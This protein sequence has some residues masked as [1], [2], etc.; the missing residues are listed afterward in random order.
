LDT[1]FSKRF[2]HY[3]VLCG[4]WQHNW[5]GAVGGKKQQ[6][7]LCRQAHHGKQQANPN[8]VEGLVSWS[9]PEFFIL[10]GYVSG[11]GNNMSSPN[12]NGG[13]VSTSRKNLPL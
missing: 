7:E 4:W 9:S 11:L 6:L 10:F 8:D 2:Y 13:Q 5:S 3:L 12:D 1:F